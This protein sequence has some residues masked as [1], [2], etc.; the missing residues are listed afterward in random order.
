MTI[1]RGLILCAGN[2]SW[3]RSDPDGQPAVTENVQG[4]LLM[5]LQ[6]QVT[7]DRETLGEMLGGLPVIA[8]RQLGAAEDNH[9]P[10]GNALATSQA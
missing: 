8:Q 2:I 3:A 7:E 1:S 9:R 10:D 6:P 4:P 5:R